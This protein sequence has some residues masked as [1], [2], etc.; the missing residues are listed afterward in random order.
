MAHP[1][2]LD[3]GKKAVVEELKRLAALGLGGVEAFYSEHPQELQDEYMAIA[4]SIGLL[5]TGGS[6]FHGEGNP[7]VRLGRGFGRL[8]VPDALMEPLRAAISASAALATGS[9][10]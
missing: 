9:S 3:L 7:A 2:T 10:R 1:C 4:T 6:D 5:A 8:N